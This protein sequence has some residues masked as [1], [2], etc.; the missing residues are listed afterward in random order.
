MQ[1]PGFSYPCDKVP[2]HFENNIVA[3][4]D[5]IVV[6]G[7]SVGAR[8]IIVFV[9]MD[10]CHVFEGLA[11]FTDYIC[12]HRETLHI[13]NVGIA[14]LLKNA[15]CPTPQT[16]FHDVYMLTLG[17]ALEIRKST[18]LRKSVKVTYDFPFTAKRSHRDQIPDTTMLRRLLAD[19]VGDAVRGA[20]ARSLMLSSGK[21]ST[22]ILVALADL[23]LTDTRCFTYAAGTSKDEDTYAGKITARFGMRHEIFRL[24][25]DPKIVRRSMEAFFKKSAFPSFDPTQAPYVL[26]L[27]MAGV[28]GGDVLDGSG[29][30]VYV[31]HVP[32]PLDRR[33]FSLNLSR[34]GTSLLEYYWPHTNPATFLFKSRS[35]NCFPG[36]YLSPSVV[37]A[38]LPST[39]AQMVRSYWRESDITHRNMDIFDFRAAVRGRHYD[40]NQ[41]ALKARTAAHCFGARTV[42]PWTDPRVADY[43]FHLPED[44]RFS[45]RDYV[46]KVLL[47][48]MLREA[49]DYPD[50]E[51]GKR[52]FE[53]E[54]EKFLFNNREFVIGEISGC[55]LWTR[56][57][58]RYATK[59]MKY[60]PDHR[61]YSFALNA[62]FMISGWCNHSQI[63]SK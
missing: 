57:A 33:K 30:D 24:P 27:A 28:D 58:E 31:G 63:F 21:D 4:D 19:A 52:F 25:Q 1:K 38:V 16:S 35:E 36:F 3:E 34:F 51:I 22:A 6:R 41:I 53:F 17:D 56:Q 54:L 44:E 29:N 10:K 8:A 13:D 11:D 5:M 47:R 37:D 23:G 49:V 32:S 12:K 18:D 20:P 45:R 59:W 48:K 15:L 46:N 43:Y 9:E 7:D 62:L 60:L 39:C 26:T 61:R 42:L 40:N 50:Q 14:H 55:K 2:L